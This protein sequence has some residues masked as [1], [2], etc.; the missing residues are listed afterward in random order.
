MIKAFLDWLKWRLFRD[1]VIELERWRAGCVDYR[2]W[3]VEFPEV[4]Y[5]LDNLRRSVSGNET[6]YDAPGL[7]EQLRN[8]RAQRDAI[9]QTVTLRPRVNLTPS[10]IAEFK[11]LWNTATWSGSL[12]GAPLEEL[13][14]ATDWAVAEQHARTVEQAH[15]QACDV[16]D[17]ALS[18]PPTHLMGIVPTSPRRVEYKFLS[19]GCE[20]RS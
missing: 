19:P 1:D 7:R 13:E 14:A 4:C 18:D 17:R 12:R 15:Q 6:Y 10:D 5:A 2:R 3:L 16:V 11:R 20:S 8:R 9:L